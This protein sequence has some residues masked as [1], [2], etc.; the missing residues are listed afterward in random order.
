M[1]PHYTS[2]TR[3]N[4]LTTPITSRFAVAM[5][6]ISESSGKG[7][8]E[9]HHSLNSPIYQDSGYYLFSSY[10]TSP[11]PPA[12]TTLTPRSSGANSLSCEIFLTTSRS[13]AQVGE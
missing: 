9:G 8:D 3:A 4:P 11:S 1:R 5:A 13:A 7:P 2:H 12:K 10:L 6:V